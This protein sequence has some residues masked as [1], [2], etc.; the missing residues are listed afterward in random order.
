MRDATSAAPNQRAGRREWT[1]LAVLA[2]ATLLVAFD[3]G[4]LFLALPH[5]SADLGATSS[6]QL[7]IT[8][9]YT[10]LLA[11]FVI[12]MGTLG[13]RI[14][15]RR[16]LLIGAVGFAL[17]SVLT[18]YS[19]SPEMLIFSRALLG[20]A[21]ATIAPST[22]ALISNM[23]RDDRQRGVA[24]SIWATCLFAGGATGPVVG[25][26]MLEHWW[27]GSVFL[28]AVPVMVVLL[29]A[30]PL[31]L[32]EYRN[33]EAIGRIDLISVALS[34]A[35]VL[36]IIYGIK[37]L[38][39]DETNLPVA[40]GAIVV[41]L[42]VA[43]VFVRRQLR[44]PNPLLDL[45]LLRQRKIR[46]VLP[47]MLVG[48]GAFGGTS[49]FTAQY[50]QSVAG[51]S[52]SESGLWLSATGLGIAAGSLLAPVLVR[53]MRPQTAIT[54]GVTGSAVA[55]LVL[56]Q[57]GASGWLIG[58][59]ASIAVVAFGVG[60]LFALGTGIVVGSAPPERAGSAASISETSNLFGTSLGLALL[61]SAGAAVYRGRMADAD[62]SAY[63]SAVADSARQTI[64]GATASGDP[65]L[66][67]LARDAFTSGLNVAA[68]IAAAVLVALVLALIISFRGDG[69]GADE[70]SAAEEVGSGTQPTPAR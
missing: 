63:P 55:L 50:I 58:V 42:A 12:T 48:A 29:V 67:A 13:D 70:A 40:V 49:M 18:A 15:R 32:P 62:L 34:L 5:L 51:R 46:V 36:P 43:F 7:W 17:A 35:A 9:I 11:G 8:D 30:G 10:F 24:I 66:I 2:V 39:A 23:F 1:G 27:W 6:Q 14:G 25:G 41:G 4:V 21:G 22:L 3:I 59:V 33:P 54:L 57:A 38:A 28:I 16:L 69:D 52:P 37:N 65:G 45:S 61:G 53:R 47:A 64:G 20:V 60:P 31:L 44:L 68:A 26:V 56:T 19:N